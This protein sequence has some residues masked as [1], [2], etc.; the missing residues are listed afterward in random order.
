MHMHACACVYVLKGTR[1]PKKCSQH[2]GLVCANGDGREGELH[3]SKEVSQEECEEQPSPKYPAGEAPHAGRKLQSRAGKPNSGPQHA[4]YS[5]SSGHGWLLSATCQVHVDRDGAATHP[6]LPFSCSLPLLCCSAGSA[7]LITT[8]REP[9][10]GFPVCK[11][12]HHGL[13]ACITGPG[14]P[15]SHRPD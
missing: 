15:K 3:F 7:Q 1:L 6:G 13:Q 11:G 9:I 4:G 2:G 14:H 8:H 10:W 5:H 12:F